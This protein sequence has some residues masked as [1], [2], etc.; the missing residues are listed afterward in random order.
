VS[1]YPTTPPPGHPTHYG[2]GQL[3]VVIREPMGSMG[4]ISPLV[5]IDGYPA[6]ARWGPNAYPITP[7]QHRVRVWARY[8]F[9]YGGAEQVVD[10]APGQSLEVHYSPP[11]ITFVRGRIGFGPQGRPGLAGLLLVLGGL[12]LIAVLIVL[13]AIFAA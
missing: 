11:M 6:P 2:Q 13:A 10:I 5:S 4:M 3:V 1:S 9:E 12:V 7:G 8:L